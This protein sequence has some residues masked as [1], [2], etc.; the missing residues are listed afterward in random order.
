[1]KKQA[2]K[3]IFIAF[4][5]L[6]GS[7]QET[8]IGLL[9]KYLRLRGEKVYLTSEPSHN[10]IGGLLRSLL[11]SHWKM[12]NVGLQLLYCADRAHH[13]ESEIRPMT[14]KGSH[15]ISSRYFFSTMAFGSLNA[16][17]KWLE[18][19]NE[20]FPEPDLTIFLDVPPKECMRRINGSRMSKEIFEKE[21][22]L[23]EVYKTYQKISH[24]KR[25]KS[26]TAVNGNRPIEA[27]AEDIRRIVDMKLHLK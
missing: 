22:K 12:S 18:A 27:I 1:M 23:K 6:D 17:L 19:I 5:G 4:E 21:Q 2:K 8:Q 14:E 11:R 7:G 26:F 20:K 9:E 24:D 3:G 13:L 16:D 25:W 10:L 15:V